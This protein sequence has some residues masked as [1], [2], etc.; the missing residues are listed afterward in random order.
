MQPYV[1]KNINEL[2]ETDLFVAL[3]GL[4]ITKG[5]GSFILDDGTGNIQVIHNDL[6]IENKSYI[7]VFG[8]VLP[9][10]DG[11]QLQGQVVQDISKIDKNLYKKVRDL[12]R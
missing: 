5:E 7:R 11:L 9:T 6:N 4:I 2:S 8:R 12:I 3:A 1:E 10:E